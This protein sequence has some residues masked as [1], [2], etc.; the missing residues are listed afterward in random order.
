MAAPPTVTLK[1]NYRCSRFLQKFYSGGAYAVSSDGSF[2]ACACNDE[3]KIVETSNSVVREILEGDGEEVTA[4]TFSPN[5]RFLFSA[6][7]SRLIRVWDLSSF[8][9]IRSWKGHDGPVTSM[10]CHSSGGLL[11]TAGAD[12]TVR[13]WDVDGGFCTH[14]FRGHTGV[15]TCIAFHPDPKCLLLF[16][17]SDDESVLVWSLESKKRI[18]ALKESDTSRVS[19]LAISEDGR[20]LLIAERGGVVT[21]WDLQKYNRQQTVTI[22]EKDNPFETVNT[23]CIIPDGSLILTCLSQCK[24]QNKENGV[25]IQP[26]YFL[27]VGEDGLVRIWSF[28]FKSSAVCIY[29]QKSSGAMPGCVKS[30]VGFLSAFVLPQNQGLLCVTSDEQFLF[31]RPEKSSDGAFQLSL[32]RRLIGYNEQI[33][34][35]AFL[36]DEEQYLGVA[37]N[38]EQLQVYDLE[39]MSCSYVLSGHAAVVLCLDS[40]KSNSGR[41]LIVT[42]SRD[43]HVRLWDAQRRSCVGIGK[44]HMGDVGAV[45]FS[46]KWKN[47]FVSGSSD[48]TIKVWSFDGVSEDVDQ[49]VTLK[50]KAVVAAHDK[51]I[52]CLAISP[53][54][55][56]VCS[57]SEDRTAC[58]WRLPELISVMVLK[59]HKR[60]IFSVEFSP[61]DQCVLTSSGDRTIKIWAISDGSCLKTFEGHT[62]G[63]SRAFFL[64]RGTQFV[65]CGFDGLVKLWTIKSNECIATYDQ[66]DERIWALAIG[67]KSEMFATGGEDAVINLWFDS[68]AADK[69]ENFRMEE[70]AILRGQELENAISDAD[71]AKAIQLAFELR[72]PHKLFELLSQLCRRDAVDPL[73]KSLR[74]IGKDE[75]RVLLE[76][77]REWNTK[78]KLCHVANFVLFRV[79]KLFPPTEVIEIKGISELLEGLIPYSQRHFSRIDRLVRSSYLLDY[80][81]NEMSVIEP[82]NVSLQSSE[83]S[84]LSSEF[85]ALEKHIPSELC[86]QANDHHEVINEEFK[87]ISPDV[88]ERVF[89]KKRKT[90]KSKKGFSAKKLKS[91]S[92]IAS[93][94]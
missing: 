44:G 76:Y 83:T 24:S 43:H 57:G 82:E 88:E 81:L 89:P 92:T 70:E 61:V 34:D 4:L 60:G 62:A 32:Y 59:G 72:R 53:I 5:D 55:S 21:I 91:A 69:E 9:C 68:T 56:L 63:V 64:S 14:L 1:K 37:T 25:A 77:V 42:G 78:P 71:Y 3:I 22:K 18:A 84:V 6:S 47:F 41:T 2:I 54:D 36:G 23:V 19:S 93:I 50:S 33:L 65:S 80:V 48:R 11:A 7:H 26:I 28:F 74:N 73:E 31:Y 52:N 27:T 49:D 86:K 13:V 29:K 90:N 66:H 17:G 10:S 94:S 15:V 40:C 45:V 79:F 75:L 87:A 20:S 8:K 51:D 38:S 30:G 67:R 16:S 46:N 85:V 58:I 12:T 35:M 39:S